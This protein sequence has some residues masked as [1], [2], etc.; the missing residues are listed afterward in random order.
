LNSRQLLRNNRSWT[1]PVQP[2]SAAEFLA[3]LRA[4]GYSATDV[5]YY[6]RTESVPDRCP[7][8][9]NR[10]VPRKRRDWI[11]IH[12]P[13]I[14]SDEL[15]EAAGRAATDNAK[16]SPRRAEPGQWLLKGLVK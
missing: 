6:N 7:T 16:W 14:I 4:S 3:G 12:C 2:R 15:F 13:R 11:P 10:Q 9:R 5:C 8:R 1:V